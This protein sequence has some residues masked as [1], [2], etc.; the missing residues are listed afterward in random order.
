MTRDVRLQKLFTI[1]NDKFMPSDLRRTAAEMIIDACTENG[2]V[3]W[4]VAVEN[5]FKALKAGD[6]SGLWRIAY[7]HQN[8]T[9]KQLD[10]LIDVVNK[11][12][13]A[14]E[15][16]IAADLLVKGATALGYTKDATKASVD[17]GGPAGFENRLQKLDD[18]MKKF[19]VSRK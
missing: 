4:K 14:G 3:D 18:T 5:Y 1:I 16:A 7:T 9:D 10:S 8:R 13:K 19:G 17:K 2:K 12:E 6:W 11:I 15:K